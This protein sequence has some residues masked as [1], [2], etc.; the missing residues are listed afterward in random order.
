MGGKADY[1]GWSR[2][3]RRY[4]NMIREFKRQEVEQARE[5]AMVEE[6]QRVRRLEEKMKAERAAGN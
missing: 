3:L 1:E 6:I 2:R 5:D 4:E